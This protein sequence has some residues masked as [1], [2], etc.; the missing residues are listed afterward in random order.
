MAR[1]I[2]LGVTQTL[3]FFKVDVWKI[4]AKAGKQ[5]FYERCRGNK[6]WRQ[7][8]FN[9]CNAL[10]N[11]DGHRLSVQLCP[12]LLLSLP[13]RSPAPV[14][15]LIFCSPTVFLQPVRCTFTTSSFCKTAIIPCKSG[16]SISIHMNSS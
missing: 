11:L 14:T 12:A 2:L 1:Q 7:V 13:L 10:D 8:Y 16:Q 6:V 15:A 3:C 4:H 9:I 5:C